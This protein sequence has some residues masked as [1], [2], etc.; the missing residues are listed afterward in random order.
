MGTRN[1]SELALGT[2]FVLELLAAELWQFLVGQI[3]SSD[4]T[5]FLE[6]DGERLNGTERKREEKPADDQSELNRSIGN[7]RDLRLSH[8][9]LVFPFALLDDDPVDPVRTGSISP[10]PFNLCRMG[11]YKSRPQ[12]SCADELKKRISEGYAIV[13]SKL[14][15]DIKPKFDARSAL[16]INCFQGTLE[17]FRAELGQADKSIEEKVNGRELSLLHL[18]CIGVCEQQSEKIRLL[19]DRCGGGTGAAV[20]ESNGFEPCGN[21]VV[22]GNGVGAGGD[23]SGTDAQRRVLALLQQRTR[24]GFSALHIAVYKGDKGALQTL[25]EAGAEPNA[26][27][28]APGVPPPLHL[29]AMSGNVEVL[30]VLVA[31]GANLQAQDFVRYT[32]LHC[33]TYFGHVQVVREL[34]EAGADPNASGGVHDRPIH[35]AA[36]KANPAMLKAFL[37]AG[38]DPTLPDDE[39]NTALHFAAKTGHC[40]SMGLLL[41]RAKDARQ[42]ALQSNLYGDTALHSAC[43]C[44]RM[45]AVKQLLAAAGSEVLGMENLFSE[46]PLMA[47]CTAGRFELVCFLMRQPEVDPNH[48]AQDGPHGA[49]FH[50]HIRVVQYLL[51]NG[52]DQSLTA[53]AVDSPLINQFGRVRDV[54][55]NPARTSENPAMSGF[56]GKMAPLGN[57]NNKSQLPATYNGIS[58]FGRMENGEKNLEQFQPQTPILWAYEKGHDQIVNMLKY[59]AN[60]R[61]D[62]DACSEYSSGSSSYTPLPSP[63]GRLRSMTKE[64]AEILQL[65]GELR[66]AHHLSLL[67]VELKEPIGSHATVRLAKFIGVFIEAKQLQSSDTRRVVA[68]G[69]KTEVDMFCREVSIV[70]H[71]KH[72]NIV[73]FVGACM[74]DPSQFAI[75]TEFASAGSLF[76]LLHVQKRVFEMALRLSIGVD[77]ARGMKYLH[78]LVER[79]VIHRDLNSHNILLHNSGR[80]V[81]ADFGE[82]RFAGSHDKREDNMTKQPGNLRWMAPEVF[83]Q[84]CRYDH[85]VDVFSYALVLWEI[86]AAE[87]PFSQLKPAAAAAKMAYERNRPQLPTEATAQFPRH[88]IQTLSNAWH[89]ASFFCLM[90]KFCLNLDPIARPEF[91][92]ILHDLEK[93]IAADELKQFSNIGACPLLTS[94]VDSTESVTILREESEDNADTTEEAEATDD[95]HLSRSGVNTVSQLKDRWEQMSASRRRRALVLSSSPAAPPS[96]ALEKLKQRVD[97]HGYVSQSARAIAAAKGATQLRDSFAMARRA[98]NVAQRQSALIR[99]A[100]ENVAADVSGTAADSSTLMSTTELSADELKIAAVVPPSSS[101]SSADNDNNNNSSTGQQLNNNS[102]NVAVTILKKKKTMHLVTAKGSSAEETPPAEAKNNKIC[103]KN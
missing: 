49:C 48:Q 88:I 99:K 76:S 56:Q 14:N 31:H 79:P 24:N 33:A 80:A 37:E 102:K 10:N 83:T 29:A 73:A 91:S 62:S 35:I 71:L 46:T 86:H 53:R 20:T 61:P 30:R 64:K 5:H 50:G 97:Q 101:S 34:L 95:Q 8:R 81:V 84:S 98:A 42:F 63:L 90:F 19:L 15:D 65:R 26:T 52:A 72:P 57:N 77:I 23:A 1:M 87:L 100:A 38:A 6:K 85:K 78:E 68:F 70:S 7:V 51:D 60:R 36:G 13:R 18:V 89:H 40:T 45:D 94:S 2:N 16:H 47:A 41:D 27:A 25:L 12:L 69:A 17:E 58:P 54:I 82:S 22:V 44:G 3:A 67:D 28:A 11:N 9:L 103:D 39:G 74:D 4:F 93:H 96:S 32:A 59:Y 43:Y 92:Q 55:K 66:S 75:I 21:A